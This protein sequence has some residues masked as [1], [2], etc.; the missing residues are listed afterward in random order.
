MNVQPIH[1]ALWRKFRVK[2]HDNVP[3]CG[4]GATRWA[5]AEVFAQLGY[6]RGAEVGVRQGLFSEAMC[7]ANPGVQLMCVDPWSPYRLRTQ[8]EQDVNYAA[9]C[10]RLEPYGC[11]IVRKTSMEAVIDVPDHSLDFVYI[12]GL[13]DFVPVMLDIIHWAKKVRTGGIISGHD[14][15]WG[16][17]AGVVAAVDAY[18]RGM[19]IIQWYLTSRD[20]E[21]S[22][23]VVQQ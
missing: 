7:K 14:Y 1:E 2:R 3:Y 18:T 20:R 16:Y 5:L 23:V 8:D 17:Q 22:W 10:K 15:C 4:W 21:P 9:A 6:T 11:Q 19:G 12:D 13:H